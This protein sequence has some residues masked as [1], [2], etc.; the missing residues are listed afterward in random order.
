MKVDRRL[1]ALCGSERRLRVLAVLANAFRPVT[2]Y[3]VS[4]VG[5]VPVSKAYDE[6]RRLEKSGLIGRSGPSGWVLLD[7]D[8]GSL[9]RKRIRAV[10][11]KDWFD[12]VDRRERADRMFP[13]RL[14]ATP[15]PR[16]SKDPGW[17][18]RHP[19]LYKRNPRKDEALT[20]MGLRPS[21]HA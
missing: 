7:P 21:K 3:R 17:T 11:W 5:G 9:L 19:S 13:D 14:R 20:E 4:L 6:L 15:R 16:F 8:L 2:G 18:P 12:R 10:W 1:V